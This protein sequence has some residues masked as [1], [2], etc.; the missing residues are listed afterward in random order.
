VLKVCGQTATAFRA[1]LKDLSAYYDTVAYELGIFSLIEEGYIVPLKVL[2]LPVKVDISDVHQRQGFDGQD[3]DKEE[4]D[5]KIAPYY[6]KIAKLI[7]E[8]APGRQVVAFLPLIKSSQEFVRICRAAGINARH[9]DG[10]SPDREEILRAFELRQFELLSNSSLL[11][12][13][14]DCPPV[15]CLLNLT[16]TRSAGIW[17]QKVGRIGRV[18]PGVIDRIPHANQRRDAIAASRK[19]DAIILD[20]LF[21]AERFG[22]QGPADLVAANVGEREAIR[23][24]LEEGEQ[25]DLMAVASDVQKDREETLKGTGRSRQRK[26]AG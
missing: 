6:E 5:T 13:G 14:W 3:Y 9:I 11:S 17:R 22:L 24:R 10:K 23:E 19:Q 8:Q 15:D 1:K 2:T 25:L 21:H 12:T 4:L 16:P 7:V 20:L 26:S 18:L